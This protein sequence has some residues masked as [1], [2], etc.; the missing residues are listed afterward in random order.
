MS[1]FT[2]NTEIQNEWDDL[3]QQ[4]YTYST[5]GDS[6]AAILVWR[7]LW[8]KMLSVLDSEAGLNIEELDQAFLGMQS[9]YNWATDYETELHNAVRKDKAFT[10]SRIDFCTDYVARYG[11]KT[12]HNILEMKRA[13]AE[14]YFQT[15]RSHDGE[16]LFKENLEVNPT[17]GWGWIGWSDQFWL[18]AEESNKN[19][20]KAISILKQALEV[21]GLEDRH[22]VLERLY[23][24][25]TDLGLYQEADNVFKE[26]M[27][28][29]EAN[30]AQRTK[31]TLSNTMKAIPVTS[32]KIGR[33]DP[34]T[35][36]SGLKY[37]KCCGK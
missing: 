20:E 33:N 29:I 6:E 17:W 12:E 9:I 31:V 27:K 11:D 10:Q 19:S 22:D 2:L 35:C 16:Q 14:T 25:Y 28:L 21:K 1:R 3:M 26:T 24:L 15:G 4:G 37:K 18:H 23:D 30:R 13:I 36:G 5:A 34:C 32:I 8:N 7:E